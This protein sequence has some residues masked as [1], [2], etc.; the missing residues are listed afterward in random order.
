MFVSLCQAVLLTALE[1]LQC[2][3]GL[4][5]D[6][7]TDL[8]RVYI[9]LREITTAETHDD[10]GYCSTGQGRPSSQLC[11]SLVESGVPDHDRRG[12]QATLTVSFRLLI[13]TADMGP[14]GLVDR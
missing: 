5:T 1:L 6:R 8:C 4:R 11:R 9:T 2:D 14:W 12:M 13:P 3:L 10:D 7:E